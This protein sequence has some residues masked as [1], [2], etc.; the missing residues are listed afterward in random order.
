VWAFCIVLVPLMGSIAFWLV[1]PEG[2]GLTESGWRLERWD[3]ATA[4]QQ[5]LPGAFDSQQEADREARKL[6]KDD[7]NTQVFVR[8]PQGVQYRVLP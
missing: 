1:R 8:G 5:R 2:K 3:V 4:S 6:V 7:P